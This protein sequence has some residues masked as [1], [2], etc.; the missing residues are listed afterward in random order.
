MTLRKNGKEMKRRPTA[1]FEGRPRSVS[2]GRLEAVRI[3]LLGGFSVSVGTQ[4]IQQSEWRLRKA[5]SLIKLLALSPNR[6]LHREHVMDLLWPDLGRRSASN[7]LRQTLHA[8]RKAFGSTVGAHYLV[9]EDELLVLCPRGDLWLDVHA[10]E[11]AA[12][13]ARRG[14]DPAA[15]RAAIDLYT[16]ELLPE[17]RYEE[18]AQNSREELRQVYLALLIEL[19]RVY[20]ERREYEK[21]IEALQRAVAEEPALEKAHRVLIRLYALLDREGEALAQYEQLQGILSREL[22]AEPS[23]ATRR[24]REE[25]VAGR[26][27]QSPPVGSL[28]EESPDPSK[29][30]LLVTRTT[31]VGRGREMLEVKRELAMTR[32]LTLTGAGGSGKTRLASEVAR[33]LVGTYP[34]GVWIVELAGLSEPGLVPQAVAAAVGVRE[35]PGQSLTDT[36]VKAL[37]SKEILLILDNCEHLIEAV[38]PL[39]D[40]FLD[41]C[42]GLRILTTSREALRVAGEVRWTVPTLS[43]PDLPGPLSV[44]ELERYES[45]RLFAERARQ[46]DPSFALTSDN[47]HAVAGICRRLDGLPLAVELAAARVGALAVAEI[48]SR[49]EDSLGLLTS[50]GR[51]AVPRQRTLRGTL[52][53]SHDSLDEYERI[54]FRRLS[55]F[56]GGWTLEAAEAAGAGDDIKKGDI[57]N[58]LSSLVDKSL[59]VTEMV[60]NRLRYRLLEPVRQYASKKL[61][62][63]DE[64]SKVRRQH[65]EYF[66]A[67]AEEAESQ[68]EGAEQRIWTDRL[69]LEHDNMRAALSW[70]LE[71]REAGLGLRL[72]GALTDFWLWQGHWSEGRRWLE[73]VLANGE[74]APPRVRAKT[75]GGAGWLAEYQGDHRRALALQ[76]ECLALYQASGDNKGIAIGLNNLGWL[77][78]HRGKYDRASELFEQ[79]L[80][81]LREGR[82]RSSTRALWPCL[83]STLYGLSYVAAYEGDL[84]R[85]VSLQE[86]ILALSQARDDNKGIAYSLGELGWLMMLRG[87]LHHAAELLEASI[88]RSPKVGP[89]NMPHLTYLGLVALGRG[90]QKRAMEAVKESLYMARE[91]GH[92]FQIARNLEAIAM[93]A[94]SQGQ[95]E[96][97]AQ[98]LGAARALRE[99]IAQPVRP[100]E[101]M[102][103]ERYVTSARAQ[104]D[105]GRWEAA[106]AEGQSMTLE[107]ALEYALS[108]KLPAT[109]APGPEQSL[110]VQRAALTRREKEVA[111][112]MAQG[113]TNRRIAEELFVSERTVE[114]HV[115]NILKKLRIQSREQ[116]AQARGDL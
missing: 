69:R 30:N 107:E 5:A 62:E 34:D 52:D 92:R 65:A 23:T 76:K 21:G 73:A 87:D 56:A 111:S 10:F 90:D 102:V 13:T 6:C 22:G 78:L 36:L 103:Y 67:L 18:W 88:A 49:L 31:F 101:R 42:S 86:E 83:E 105:E 63:S 15:Y 33:D 24:L 70:M 20:E 116:V 38:A 108:E 54:V 75:L 7:N 40:V 81:R 37:R 79:S 104:I 12:A 93:L 95:P 100:D 53:W 91:L 11:E 39:V 84:A 25:I 71:Q 8:A 41:T 115:S 32:L 45:A 109:P 96:R 106:F 110:P 113:L 98:L 9:S 55:V 50:G 16:G 17:D 64:D 99:A 61:E 60:E 3:K 19:A 26:F 77:K 68:L 57:V 66:L 82:K 97:I 114:N 85:A 58:L 59:V 48:A 27:P 46:R 1:G 94:S 35:Q 72:G 28:L 43:S 74:G 44:S 14:S 80:K 29:H 112:L 47:A 4:T 51:T 89:L 2:T